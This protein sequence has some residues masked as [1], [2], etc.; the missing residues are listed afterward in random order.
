MRAVSKVFVLHPCGLPQPVA[1]Q[2]LGLDPP[3][4]GARAAPLPGG[5]GELSAG[6]RKVFARPVACLQ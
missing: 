2:V 6:G 1:G 3:A 5:D 4:G